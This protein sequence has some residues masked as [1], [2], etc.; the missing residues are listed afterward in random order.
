MVK[1]VSVSELIQGITS[2]IDSDDSNYRA[3]HWYDREVPSNWL[4]DDAKEGETTIIHGYASEVKELEEQ[5]KKL[6]DALKFYANA[7]SW[8][9]KRG[10]PHC[11]K[12]I[13]NDSQHL[14]PLDI[15]HN[16]QCG[17]RARE[18]LKEIEK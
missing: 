2:L 11:N 6:I 8:G 5:N 13:S 9:V 16:L 10:C 1:E 12:F 4:D 15:D 3:I 17:Q 14:I 7:D 18:A